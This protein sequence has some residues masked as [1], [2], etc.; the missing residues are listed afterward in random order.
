MTRAASDTAGRPELWGGIECSLVRIGAHFRY[1]LDEQRAALDESQLERVAAL[2]FRRL[3]F[4]VLWETV[5]PQRPDR[6]DWRWHD[7]MLAVLRRLGVPPIAGL[8]HHGSGPRYTNLLDPA[9]PAKLADYAGAVARRYPWIDAYTPV[10]EPLTTAR[11]S[12]LY[13]FWYPHA[14]DLASCLRALVNECRGTVL[15]MQAIRRINPQAQLI[16]TEDLGKVYAVPALRYQAEHENERR[17]LS[18]DLL[19]GRVD[20]AHPM[21]DL[22]L[23]SGVTADELAL[24]R[25]S[26]ITPDVLGVNHYLTSDR[27]LDSRLDPYPSDHHGGNGRDAYADVEAVRVAACAAD[28]GPLARLR[29]L[30]QRYR[31]PIA[32]TEAHHGCTREEQ[33]RWLVEVWQAACTARAEGADVRAVTVWSLLGATDWNSLL[34]HRAAHYEA[35]CFDARSAPPRP[36]LLAN[37]AGAL[38]R[39]GSFAHPVLAAPGWWC[40]PER[41]YERAPAVARTRS[42]STARPLLITGGTGTL[43]RAL[44]RICAH[45]GLPCVLLSRRDMDIADAAAVRAMLARHR[46]WAVINAA[47][48]VRVADAEREQ[49]RCLRENLVG[50][51]VIAAICAERAT[52]FATFSSDLV[53]DGALGRAYV[54]SDAPSPRCVYGASKAQAEDAVIAAWSLALVIRTS[55]FFGPWD[56]YNF[57]H[58]V[59]QRLRA[60]ATVE[61]PDNV[62]VSPTYVPD[63]AHATLDLLLDGEAGVWHVANR[64]A[65]SWFGLARSIAEELALDRGRVIQQPAAHGVC[66][67]LSSERGLLLPS[68][69]SAI[70]RFAREADPAMLC[71]DGAA[72]HAT[73]DTADASFR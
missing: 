42:T 8:V 11:F 68:L 41:L 59:V 50:A 24:L 6:R 34:V 25:D 66:T 3:R 43:G 57:A 71:R 61:V 54:E 55:G 16:H 33:L 38:A 35:G 36:T 4:P 13:G 2:G 28:T 73:A 5:A 49:D 18:Y 39:D 37:A 47:G 70:G 72:R 1:Q 45:R 40:R 53:F 64:G 14:R 32:V 30:W 52:A 29:E 10:N 69:E 22:L 58:G 63:L 65:T 51:R 31:L 27:F 56:R 26:G 9:F 67:A 20:A 7:R 46:P 21:Y 12:A 17:W 44:A 15:A 48:Y 62:V 23:D 19:L 60:G